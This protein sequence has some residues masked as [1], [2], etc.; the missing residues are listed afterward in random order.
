MDTSQTLQVNCAE[1][2]ELTSQDIVN[3]YKKCD[4][5]AFADFCKKFVPEVKYGHCKYCSLKLRPVG[6]DRTSQRTYNKFTKPEHYR[7]YHKA[8]KRRAL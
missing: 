5:C 2:W 1:C 3:K 6:R 7:K 8:C 4:N